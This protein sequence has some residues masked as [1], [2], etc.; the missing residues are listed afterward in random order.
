[1][2]KYLLGIIIRQE[3]DL[4]THHHEYKLCINCIQIA[5]CLIRRAI[6]LLGIIF[7]KLFISANFVI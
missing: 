6:R 1:M 3:K 5:Y 7:T 4:C 2:L